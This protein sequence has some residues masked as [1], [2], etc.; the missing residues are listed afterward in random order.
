MFI[1][2]PESYVKLTEDDNP[3]EMGYD[4]LEFKYPGKWCV[5]HSN[6]RNCKLESEDKVIRSDRSG[7]KYDLVG[8]YWKSRKTHKF[9]FFD[10]LTIE[11]ENMTELPLSERRK[12]FAPYARKWKVPTWV[13]PAASTKISKWNQLWRYK[14]LSPHMGISYPGLVFKKKSSKYGK[15]W[16]VLNKTI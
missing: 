7:F 13:F 9:S 11:G 16:A 4:Y 1:N 12:R 2:P 8:H 6:G 14:V 15:D 3:I 10:V 5:L